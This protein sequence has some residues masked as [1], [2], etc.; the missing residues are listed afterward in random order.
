M[1]NALCLSAARGAWLDVPVLRLLLARARALLWN[2]PCPPRG[3]VAYDVRLSKWLRMQNH[4]WS[5]F[6]SLVSHYYIYCLE[7]SQFTVHADADVRTVHGDMLASRERRRVDRSAR[8]WRCLPKGCRLSCCVRPWQCWQRRSDL[9][10]A[11]RW[12]WL[13]ATLPWVTALCYVRHM[14]GAV[15]ACGRR[16]GNE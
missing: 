15:H 6:P 13:C 5:F 4:G 3:R 7:W 14:A 9:R 8:D 11:S 16:R 1:L 12:R 10:N 2:G